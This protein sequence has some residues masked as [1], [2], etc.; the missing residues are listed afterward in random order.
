MGGLIKAMPWTA[1]TFLVGAMAISALPP[2]N[3]FVSEWLTLQAFFMG[4]A[5]GTIGVKIFMGALAGVLALTG[6]LAAA[7]FVK[8]FGITFLAMPRSKNAAEAKESPFSMKFA[9][10]FL[11][12]LTIIFGLAAAPII[13]VLTGVSGSALAIDTAN[14]NF[15]FN[16]FI[17]TPQGVGNIYLSPLIAG[18][19]LIFIGAAT[20]AA[21]YFALGKPKVVI[22]KTWDC[23]YYKL[24]SRNEYTATA[25]SKPFRIAFDFFLLP[26]RKTEKIRDS[27]YHIKSFTYEVYTTPVF[28]QYIYEP[29]LRAILKIAN[30]MKKIQSGS[31]HLYIFYIF[32]TILTLIIFMDRF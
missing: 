21:L 18:M 5:G 16:N 31:I 22:N 2:L 4:L 24:N 12:A 19:A 26:Y 11:A 20:A 30:N 27:F 7:C 32:I 15:T 6:G 23:G 28:K 13:K 1:A 10:V 29:A 9:M 17:I 25:F 14:I 3:G 8:A